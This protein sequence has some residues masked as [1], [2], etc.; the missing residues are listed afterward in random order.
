MR[1]SEVLVTLGREELS[2]GF[3]VQVWT[4]QKQISS[5][6]P[7]LPRKGESSSPPVG[8]PKMNRVK[9]QGTYMDACP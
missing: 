4:A 3:V 8:A 7:T 6:C 2:S 9:S 5:L 1:W